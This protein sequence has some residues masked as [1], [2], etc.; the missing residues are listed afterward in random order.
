MKYYEIY[1]A[2]HN[3]FSSYVKTEKE[4][5]P[6]ELEEHILQAA[7]ALRLIDREDA[8]DVYRGDGYIQEVSQS[9][10]VE[11]IKEDIIPEI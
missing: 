5:P 11:I 9:E 8:K 7:V 2:G 1:V 6:S 4:F 10:I 3:G